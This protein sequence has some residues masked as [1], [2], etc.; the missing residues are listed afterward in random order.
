MRVLGLFF[1]FLVVGNDALAIQSKIT[2][3]RSLLHSSSLNHNKK[4]HRTHRQKITTRIINSLADLTPDDLVEFALN[5]DICLRTSAAF[6]REIEKVKAQRLA[7]SRKE[8]LEE[9]AI[10]EKNKVG[11]KIAVLDDIVGVLA[12]I[13]SLVSVIQSIKEFCQGL[14]K[15][16]RLEMES[17]QTAAETVLLVAKG[18]VEGFKKEFDASFEDEDLSANLQR[19]KKSIS[20]IEKKVE[21]ILSCLRSATNIENKKTMIPFDV[22]SFFFM[23]GGKIVDKYDAN[24]E[25]D[26][27]YCVS[28]SLQADITALDIVL[29][30]VYDAAATARSRNT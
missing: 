29:N 30:A 3:H 8:F 17:W 13:G 14:S 22:V 12:I 19:L 25:R 9:G 6:N 23:F 21:S 7:T 5:D 15:E 10:V 26:K 27:A 11:S 18:K 28:K 24:E 2:Q 16:K 1:L 4:L 20:I